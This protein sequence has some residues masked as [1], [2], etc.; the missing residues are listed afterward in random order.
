M[1][2]NGTVLGRI[3]ESFLWWLRWEWTCSGKICQGRENK[4]RKSTHLR[5]SHD[6]RKSDERR[7]N[8]AM[9]VLRL[10]HNGELIASYKR[11]R[12]IHLKASIM[13]Q[14]K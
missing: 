1:T 8:S 11:T 5:I 7:H 4:E 3:K 2:I 10:L 9:E 6:S 13:H 14:P 12:P